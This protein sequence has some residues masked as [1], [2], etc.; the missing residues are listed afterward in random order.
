MVVS[1]GLGMVSVELM[2]YVQ[3]RWFTVW[4]HPQLGHVGGVSRVL[5]Y[6]A[7]LVSC[8]LYASRGVATVLRIVTPTL[9]R[10]ALGGTRT[11]ISLNGNFEVEKTVYFK[12]YFEARNW[13]DDRKLCIGRNLPG[14]PKRRMCL[15][16]KLYG[17]RVLVISSS[18]TS[19]DTLLMTTLREGSAGSVNVQNS[20]LW[21]CRIFLISWK[22]KW[23]TVRSSGHIW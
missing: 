14:V 19:V 3:P 16:V 5:V 13:C 15:T 20:V 17:V 8:V 9:T 22:C 23:Q 2:R 21:V 6:F 4:A 11:S 7:A 1:E 18:V 12:S 10:K